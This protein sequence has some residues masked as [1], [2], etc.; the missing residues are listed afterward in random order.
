MTDF[1]RTIGRDIYLI[2]IASVATAALSTYI[3]VSVL[4]NDMTW[5]KTDFR[6]ESNRIDR[7]QSD[8]RILYSYCTKGRP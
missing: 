5:I 6:H 1:L 2:V 8:L 4:K 3:N 7:T